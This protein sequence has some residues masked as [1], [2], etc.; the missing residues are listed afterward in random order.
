MIRFNG[1]FLEMQQNCITPY[2]IPFIDTEKNPLLFCI[3]MK[4]NDYYCI[5]YNRSL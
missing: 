4:V 1:N 3:F 5:P 2:K